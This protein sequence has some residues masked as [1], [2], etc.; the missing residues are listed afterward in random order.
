MLALEGVVTRYGR[1]S[2]LHGVS[3]AVGA[4]EFVCLI[5]ANGA[6]KST[7]LKTIS[8]LLRPA[9]GRIVFDGRRDPGPAA[10]GD[11]AP[12]DRPLS[13]GPPRVPAT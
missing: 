12:R 10:P 11:P 1:I 7:T 5:G 6:G 2:A 9:E 4:G 13:R 3:L 8:G